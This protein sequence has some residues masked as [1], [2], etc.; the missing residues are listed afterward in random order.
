MDK[1]QQLTLHTGKIPV[2]A[3]N[4]NAAPARI[5]GSGTFSTKKGHLAIIGMTESGKST[6]AHSIALNYMKAGIPVIVLEP[7]KSI[8]WP[9]TFQTDSLEEFLSVAKRS[10]KCAIFCEESGRFGRDPD[11]AWL[12]TE[13]RQEGHVF[14]YL[15]QY[16]AQVPPIARTNC[17]RLAL[18]LVGKKSAIQ[19]ADDFGQPEIAE[20]N[21]QL[22]IY[23]FV[24]AN[25]L[26]NPPPKILRLAID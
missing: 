2:L 24:S 6:L 7:R 3:K 4:A 20:L 1:N 17:L 22:P 9:C 19:W 14:H 21:Q 16:H 5:E 8:Q 18:F 15:S 23:G 11:F 13:S 26:R 12:F 25:R 10:R